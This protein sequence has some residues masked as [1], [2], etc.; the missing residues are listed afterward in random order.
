[1]NPELKNFATADLINEVEERLRLARRRQPVIWWHDAIEV[2]LNHYQMTEEKLREKS[3]E[4]DQSEARGVVMYL[5]RKHTPHTLIEIGKIFS[6][7][8]GTVIH[9][10]NRIRAE[11]RV[12]R[13]FDR[14][15]ANI[16]ASYLRRVS[17]PHP[18]ALLERVREKRG[19]SHPLTTS[20]PSERK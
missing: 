6:K 5:L 3:R 17:P 1:M 14:K 16:E 10:F 12:S 8:H 11:R 18:A 19:L 7:D 4:R 2:V 20:S 9:W 13:R 15:I